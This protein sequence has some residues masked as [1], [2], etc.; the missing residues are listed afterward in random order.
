MGKTS[1]IIVQSYGEKERVFKRICRNE[2]SNWKFQPRTFIFFLKKIMELAQI[3][4][5]K[6]IFYAEMKR[7]NMLKILYD[8]FK[9]SMSRSTIVIRPQGM[10]IR[11]SDQDETILFDCDYPAR[12]FTSY[13][14]Q[15][16]K[17][18]NV[19]VEHMTKQLK[20]A[21]KKDTI[22]LFI[23]DDEKK[24]LL[25]ISI[26][27]S[28]KTPSDRHEINYVVFSDSDD[29]TESEIPE[30]G[31]YY[32]PV[33]VNA[34][35]FQKI[36]KQISTCRKI[37]VLM[38]GKFLQFQSGDVMP[39]II[40]FGETGEVSANERYP[41]ELYSQKFNSVNFDMILKL[42]GLCH[43]MNFFVPYIKE[44]YPL[45]INLV[46]IQNESVFGSMNVFIKDSRLIEQEASMKSGFEIRVPRPVHEPQKRGR[47]KIIR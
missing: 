1:I 44:P 6:C 35:D 36:K 30:V 29:T 10:K 13:I 23:E 31:N 22:C 20:N 9:K 41:I 34:S 43:Q 24:K 42:P 46:I 2:M 19:R 45:M 27:P 5:E 11:D 25:G 21:K 40:S 33:T 4:P 12:F 14:A 8:S 3:Q 17:N 47:K 39:S 18:I 32:M 38:K 15:K 7:G 37:D 28:G 26:R 16:S